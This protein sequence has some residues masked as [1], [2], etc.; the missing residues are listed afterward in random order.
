VYFVLYG[1]RGLMYGWFLKYWTPPSSGLSPCIIDLLGRVIKLR[2]H[3][4]ME[5]GWNLEVSSRERQ[6]VR[7]LRVQVLGLSQGWNPRLLPTSFVA[8]GN[9]LSTSVSWFMGNTDDGKNST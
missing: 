9:T 3:R 1:G 7:G 8:L 6:P 4:T 2:G 5:G